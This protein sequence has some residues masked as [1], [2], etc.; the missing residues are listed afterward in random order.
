MNLFEALPSNFFSILSSKN[1]EI[2]ADCL[3]ILYKVVSSNTSF[4]V[5]R[6]IVVQT[7][8]D[9]FE[10][11][12]DESIFTEDD[13]SIKSSREEANF[14]LRKFEDCGWID[15]ETTNNYIQILNLKDYA[16]SVLETLNKIIHNEGLEYQGYVYTI[17][18][19][20]FT[21]E[22]TAYNIMLEQVYENTAK[23]ING[24]KSLNSN[25]KKY[26][27]IITTK[28][29]PDEI[30]K[31]HFEGYAQD[32]IDK[33]YH[34]LKT[35]DNVSKFRPRIIERLEEIRKDSEFIQ[36]VCKQNLE[37]DKASSSEDAF[38]KVIYALNETINAFYNIDII[39]DE[40]DRKNFQYIRASL[41]RVKYLLNSSRDLSGQ[42]NEIFKYVVNMVE[43]N[44]LDIKS[45][46]IEEISELFSFFPQSF[47]DEKSL[48]TSTEGKQAFVSQSIEKGVIT[49]E[50]R[51]KRILE[52][53]EKNKNRMSRDNIDKYVLQILGD[54][55]TT[56]ASMLPLNDMNDYIKLIY[57]IVYSR[58]KLVHYRIK[59]LNQPVNIN[60]FNFNDFEIWRK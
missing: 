23:L 54:R 29:T 33:G 26:I 17:Y 40:I 37:M 12:D 48:Y 59:K 4:G 2:Y 50:E 14:I 35:S 58:S 21:K 15:I 22:N 51:E 10:T 46:V 18:S 1:K 5:E 27:D 43:N 19:I 34:R 57:I 20:L 16:I 31:L 6:E 30:M 45:E 55:K 49:K 42:V 13:S 9:Y 25:I 11:L 44:N 36:L 32:I 39:I 8:T 38:E 60:S 47:I 3:F 24:L 56:N 52:L 53:K 7:L 28:K 41:T